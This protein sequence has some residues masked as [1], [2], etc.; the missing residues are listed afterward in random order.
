M[1]YVVPINKQYIVT[2]IELSVLD[3]VECFTL[4]Y[5]LFSTIC[6]KHAQFESNRGVSIN[7]GFVEKLILKI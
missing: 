6:E 2:Y 7:R 1:W 3:H 5:L 4:L